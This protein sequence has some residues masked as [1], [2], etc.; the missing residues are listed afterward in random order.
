[1]FS[2]RNFMVSSPTFKSFIHLELIFGSGLVGG[3]ISFFCLRLASFH[4]TTD[5]RNYSF[6]IEYSW[7]PCEGLVY[8]ICMGF[9]EGS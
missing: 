3:P 6:P 5:R 8:H 9:A 1:M 7:F 4:N 2:F